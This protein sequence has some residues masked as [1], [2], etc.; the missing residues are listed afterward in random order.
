MFVHTQY[1]LKTVNISN[2]SVYHNYAVYKSKTVLFQAAH[3][4]IRTHFSLFFLPIDRTLSGATTQ[5][6]IA[7]G[8]DGNEWVLHVP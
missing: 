2:D 3:F 8:S 1:N 6:Q 4:I 7:P 5:D